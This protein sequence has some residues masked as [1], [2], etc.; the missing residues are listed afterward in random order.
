[1]LA[2]SEAP[3]PWPRVPGWLLLLRRSPCVPVPGVTTGGDSTETL[4]PGGGAPGVPS[5]PAPPDGVPASSSEVPLSAAAAVGGSGPLA[6][7]RRLRAALSL[8]TVCWAWRSC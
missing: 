7:A 8:A 5:P 1:M 6:G 2:L 3:L 4:A